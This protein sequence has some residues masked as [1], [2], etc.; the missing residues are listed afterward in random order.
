MI[1]GQLCR[2]YVLA[3][4]TFKAMIPFFYC[5]LFMVWIASYAIII[6][7]II[8][9]LGTKLFWLWDT[10]RGMNSYSL[11]VINLVTN[12]NKVLHKLINLKFE[13]LNKLS[14]LGTSV[15]T[16]SSIF[17]GSQVPLKASCTNLCK[18][19]LIRSHFSRKRWHGYHWV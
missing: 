3:R 7:S 4:S 14:T 19:S 18:D 5:L 8:V 11:R 9:H 10:Q 16:I 2:L 6:V 12:F 1:N 15:I 17:P 13:G